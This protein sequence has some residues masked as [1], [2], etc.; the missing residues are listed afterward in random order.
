[1]THLQGKAVVI[2]GAARGLGEAYARC[3][4]GAGASVVVNDIDADL[5]D[6]VVRRIIAAGG[7]AVSHNGD[8]SS[9]D[10]AESLIDRCVTEFGRIDGLVNNAGVFL[11]APIEEHT[12]EMIKTQLEANLFGHAYCGIHALRRMIG[13]RSGSVINT[14]SGTQAGMAFR[15][16]YS[17]AMA[18]IAGLTRSWAHECKDKNVRVNAI[19]PVANTREL[20]YGDP[21]LKRLIAEG[22]YSQTAFDRRTKYR[23][24]TTDMNVPMVLY[25]LSDLSIGITGQGIRYTGDELNLM[26]HAVA[27]APSIALDGDLTVEGIARFFSGPWKDALLPLGLAEFQMEQV[28]TLIA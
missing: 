16:S 19:A 21:I 15:C 5:A 18:G 14:Y 6:D 7:R 17:A 8:V 27:R 10:L 26:S 24:M 28:R 23:A 4:A 25:F 11:M 9:W 2:T 1:M 12:E 22:R 13:Q 20:D 3:A